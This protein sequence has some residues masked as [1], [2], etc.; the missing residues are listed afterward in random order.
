MFIKEPRLSNIE[1]SKD[2]KGDL[3]AIEC[4]F[5]ESFYN[6]SYMLDLKQMEAYRPVLEKVDEEFKN[7]MGIRQCPSKNKISQNRVE[8]SINAY[9]DRRTICQGRISLGHTFWCEAS[10][11]TAGIV[12]YWAEN[13]GKVNYKVIIKDKVIF[14]SEYKS[15]L[16]IIISFFTLPFGLFDVISGSYEEYFALAISRTVNRLKQDLGRDK[17]NI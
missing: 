17:N 3:F 13:P 8:L 4:Y 11:W 7:Q 12:P 1:K 6:D 14:K 15:N 16:I 5:V 9:Y 2:G 10:F